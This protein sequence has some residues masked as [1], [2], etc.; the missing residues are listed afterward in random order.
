MVLGGKEE[1]EEMKEKRRKE[2]ESRGNRIRKE[3]LI[4]RGRRGKEKRKTTEYQ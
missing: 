3:G 4:G 1:R 2:E